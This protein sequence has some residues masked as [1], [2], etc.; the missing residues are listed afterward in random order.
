M[1]PCGHR[2][3]A[4][5]SHEE[6]ESESQESDEGGSGA[7]QSVEA[8]GK[9]GGGR[10]H[11]VPPRQSTLAADSASRQGKA[12]R[13]PGKVVG[14]LVTVVTARTGCT[15]KH[16]GI[17]WSRGCERDERR[18]EGT[19]AARSAYRNSRYIG[20]LDAEAVLG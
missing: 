19:A 6:G 18:P 7:R 16:N 17:E 5:R 10:R 8:G 11:L 1:S 20:D 12:G 4:R 9:G 2:Q 3:Q 15:C 14:G 13:R